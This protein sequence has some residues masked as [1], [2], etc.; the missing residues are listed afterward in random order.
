MGFLNSLFG[1]N[2]NEAHE[3]F[4]SHE[5]YMQ[6]RAKQLAWAPQTL[7]QLRKYGVTDQTQ[8]KLEYFFYSDGKNKAEA[9]ALKLT[10]LGYAGGY[11]H[12]ASDRKQFVVTGWTARMTMDEQTILSWTARMCDLGYEY[13]C[14]FD[15][16]GTSPQ[17]DADR[18][19]R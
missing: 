11:D 8:L 3:R 16:W 6:N 18:Q 1:R 13:D 14:E 19:P 5:T 12:S 15:G 9:L 17:Q 10:D 2:R 4:Q 7:E